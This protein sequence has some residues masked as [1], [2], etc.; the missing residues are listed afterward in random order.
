MSIY[1]KDTIPFL[2]VYSVACLFD[3]VCS[4][5]PWAAV[6]IKLQ[7]VLMV[8]YIVEFTVKSLFLRVLGLLQSYF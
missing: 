2:P 7:C 4:L 6:T 1:R 5:F 8:T 3:Y